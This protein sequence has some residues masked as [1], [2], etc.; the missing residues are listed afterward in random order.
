M[1]L[2]VWLIPLVPFLKGALG[3]SAVSFLNETFIKPSR[4]RR[5]IATVLAAEVQQ[6]LQMV[7]HQ[8]EYLKIAP[9]TVTADFH[10]FNDVY[11]ALLAR[12][13][14][15]PEDVVGD[16]VLFHQ[17]VAIVNL[18]TARLIGLIDD[19][20][21]LSN[22]GENAIASKA[23]QGNEEFV[24]RAMMVWRAHFPVLVQQGDR[25]L[26]R[27]RVAETRFGRLG[28]YFRKKPSINVDQ[29]GIEVGKRAAALE[30]KE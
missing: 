18:D 1:T 17:R 21:Q 7:V 26:R 8:A 24:R 4:S 15:L 13:A 5:G 22:A 14:E 16:L 27:L 9:K 6:I 29:V 10:L 23:Y 11:R 19:M 20:K 2:P 30:R 28:Y 25:I 12:I 3:W